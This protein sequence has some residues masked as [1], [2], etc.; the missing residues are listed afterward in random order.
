MFGNTFFMQ[1]KY[2]KMPDFD[3]SDLVMSFHRSLSNASKQFSRYLLN[4][5]DWEDRLIGLRGARESGKT[6]ILLQ[7]IN[8]TASKGQKSLH[9]SLDHLTMTKLCLFFLALAIGAFAG[10]NLLKDGSASGGKV[11]MQGMEMATGADGRHCFEVNPSAKVLFSPDFIE[12]DSESSYVLSAEMTCASA[13]GKISVGLVPYDAAKQL[14]SYSSLAYAEGS[15]A[16]LAEDAAKGATTLVFEGVKDWETLRKRYF[17]IIAMNAKDDFTDLPNRELC[18]YI[19]EIVQDGTCSKVTLNHPIAK[20]YKAGTK[21]R[22]HRDGGYLWSLMENG[23]ATTVWKTYSATVGGM[24]S[25]GV[26]MNQFWKGTKYVK[27]ALM[28]NGGN[29]PLHIDKLSFSKQDDMHDGMVHAVRNLVHEEGAALTVTS[30]E[31]IPQYEQSQKSD[32]SIVIEA[33]QP[34]KLTE[35][36]GDIPCI[37]SEDGCGAGAYLHHVRNATYR[38]TVEKG[39]K[40]DFYYRHKMPFAGNWNHSEIL[41]EKSC[42]VQDSRTGD[43][44]FVGKWGWNK[45]R[46]AELSAGTHEMSM[47]YQGGAMLDQIAILPEGSGAPTGRLESKCTSVSKDK[48]VVLGGFTA[49]PRFRQAEVSYSAIGTM[50]VNASL[51]GGRT[52]FP[53]SDGHQ[54]PDADK[55]TPVKIKV[56]ASGSGGIIRKLRIGCWI[57]TEIPAEKSHLDEAM[58]ANVATAMLQPSKWTG[59]RWQDRRLVFNNYL[60]QDAK[61][62]IFARI[63]DA[64]NMLLSPPTRSWFEKDERMD[65][66]TVLYQGR[67]NRNLLAFD[68]NLSNGGKYRPYF[69]MRMTRPSS[70]VMSFNRPESTG[71]KYGY[72]MDG[73]LS[74]ISGVGQGTKFPYGAYGAGKYQWWGGNV[75]EL[76]SGPHTLRILWGMYYMNIAAIALIPEGDSPVSPE[77]KYPATSARRP[78]SSAIVEY[79]KINGRLLGIEV[80]DS[81]CKASFDISYDNGKTFNELPPLPMKKSIEFTLRGRF[82]GSGAIP[83]VKAALASSKCIAVSDKRQRMLFD[84]T[85]GNLMGYELADGTSLI[86]T[87]VSQPLF[88]MQVG[89]SRHGFRNVAPD[90]GSLIERTCRKL[91]NGQEMSLRFA[92]ADGIEAMVN[93]KLADGQLPE[94]ELTVNNSSSEDVRNI[95]FPI[96]PDVRISRNPEEAFST[97]IRNLCAFGYPG[98]PFGGPCISG[99][100][101]P[102]SYSM[103]YSE[104]YAKGVGSFTLQNRNPDGIGVEFIRL[105]DGGRSS[106]KLATCRRYLIEAGKSATVKYAGGFLDGDEHDACELYGKWAHTW[107]DFSMVNSPIAKNISSINERSYFPTD[108]TLNQMIPI[109]RWLGYD[110]HWH[111]VTIGFT[112]LYCPSYGTSEQLAAQNRALEA[113]GQPLVQYWDHYGW[114]HLWETSTKLREYPKN[115][116]PFVETLP[117]VGTTEKAAMRTESGNIR[118][119]GYEP[120]SNTMCSADKFWQDHSNFVMTKHFFER[121]GT[122]GVY[123]DEVCVY[124]ECYNAAHSH[125]KQYGM[126]MVGQGEIFKKAIRAAKAANRPYII[127]GEG[128]PDYLLQFEEF[129][130]RSGHDALDGA[131]LLFAFPEVKFMRGQANHPIDGIPDWCEAVRDYHLHARSDV[132]DFAGNARHF[133]MH[134]RRIQDWMYNGAFRDDV[135]LEIS[136]PGVIAKYFLRNDSSHSGILMNLRNEREFGGV[137]ISV[138]TSVIPDKASIP[139]VALC[140][141]MEEE[142]VKPVAIERGKDCIS[143][144][145]PTA[146]ASSVLIPFRMPD[147]E[148]LRVDFIWPQCKGADRFRITAMNFSGEA[149]E[150]PLSLKL[151]AGVTA[152]DC[153][154]KIELAPWQFLSMEVKFTGRDNL[155]AISEAT[156]ICGA[157]KHTIDI[158]PIIS[159]R[160]FENHPSDGISAD[161]WGTNSFYYPHAFRQFPD[162]A[163]D[164]RRIGGVVD[165]DKPFDGK[166]SLRLPGHSA[167]LPFPT[168][169]LAGPHGRFGYPKQ[170]AKLPWFYNS[171]QNAIVKP[172]TKYRLEFVCRFASD[173]GELRLQAFPYTERLGQ[174]SFMFKTQT[175]KPASG[176]RDWRKHSLEF[177]TANKLFNAMQTPVNFVNLAPSDVWIDAVS[178][179]EVAE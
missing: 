175:F 125:G 107:M 158:A 171:Q 110:M 155:E 66:A 162:V 2:I 114:S 75:A 38:F 136:R 69:L 165:A 118:T 41:G 52:W 151:P 101:W 144:A 56:T 28:Y 61:G 17:R 10:D 106:I 128:S 89:N 12:V 170:E 49:G 156:L 78:Q 177:T 85:T 134:R 113:A 174:V 168:G 121:Y 104:L 152:I 20:P 131:P 3:I 50:A 133:S 95:L 154:S 46:S 4:E 139:P 142:R 176:D 27:I 143:F 33:E 140:Y 64:D 173:D 96:F 70:I 18:Y 8:E 112:H 47:N 24:S 19:K 57:S 79:S 80:G 105:P 48:S 5:I 160:S 157:S 117:G 73:K 166:F 51:D 13:D 119:W 149:V 132:P 32:G 94:W 14:I 91:E 93:V 169:C 42:T 135:G 36:K 31:I 6:T 99:G 44:S 68:F 1:R 63:T 141:L 25:R 43:E 84:V 92:V 54:I 76:S 103:G 39:G 82:E 86:P 55:E 37:V 30:N 109:S 71:M 164:I 159:N 58:L 74:E 138:S 163:P 88:S 53:V 7:H 72:A 23:K 147:N 22:L 21:C 45:G 11:P 111:I 116:I 62:N 60:Q 83:E 127:A 108:R 146:K 97:A 87:S 178:L 123:S 137:R 35:E 124:T 15:E 179:V 98:A 59:L 77:L 67:L 65:G 90:A 40:F 167:P 29:A 115:I 102:G 129:G 81:S 100:I 161:F 148:K 26:P 16:V 153:P 126:K 120:E 9:A 172:G 122:S 130:L 145:A 150:R 34:W